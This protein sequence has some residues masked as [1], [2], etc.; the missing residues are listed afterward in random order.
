MTKG[1]CLAIQYRYATAGPFPSQ[2]LDLF[3]VYLSLLAPPL[4]SFHDAVPAKRIILAGESVG[5]SLCV[6]F[7]QVLS[8][9]R[10]TFKSSHLTFHGVEVALSLPAGIA[11][12]SGSFDNTGGLPSWDLNGKYDYQAQEQPIYTAAWPAQPLWPSNPP[13]GDVYCET[14][15]LTHPL[16]CPIAIDN[17]RGSPPLWLACGEE[18]GA[19]GVK[20]IAQK[21][22]RQGVAVSFV[23]YEAMPHCWTSVLRRYPHSERAMK[24]WAMACVEMVKGNF[25]TRAEAVAFDSLETKLLDVTRLTTWETREIMSRIAAKR[26]VRVAYTVSALRS[27]P[28]L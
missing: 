13:R 20:L 24:Q 10:T 1:R 2:L 23:E 3:V 25:S 6:A 19:D 27:K 12:V 15:A 21:A 14:S 16:V 17:F 18:R 28:L 22:A 8:R 7:V 5:L 9:L 4:Q 26:D 11:G